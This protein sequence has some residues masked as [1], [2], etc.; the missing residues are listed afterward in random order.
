M[1]MEMADAHRLVM[2][3]VLMHVMAFN[4]DMSMADRIAATKEL[5]DGAEGDEAEGKPA[6]PVLH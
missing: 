1:K 5:L 4:D 6:E 2:G 3:E